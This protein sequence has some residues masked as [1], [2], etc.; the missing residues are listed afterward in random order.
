MEN[1]LKQIEEALSAV[2]STGFEMTQHGDGVSVTIY[3]VRKGAPVYATKSK[4]A[5]GYGKTL[6]IAFTKALS[7][8]TKEI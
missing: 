7:L 3:G 2:A 1:A 4:S 5:L 6:T 8:F